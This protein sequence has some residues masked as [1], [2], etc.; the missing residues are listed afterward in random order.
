MIFNNNKIFKTVTQ[1]ESV[2]KKQNTLSFLNSEEYIKFIFYDLT[3]V[4]YE[5]NLILSLSKNL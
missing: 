1:K 4:E 3:S 2:I 5:K